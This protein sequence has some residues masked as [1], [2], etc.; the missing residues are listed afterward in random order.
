[1]VSPLNEDKVRG[2]HIGIKNTMVYWKKRNECKKVD[3][4]QKIDNYNASFGKFKDDGTKLYIHYYDGCKKR[5]RYYELRGGGHRWPDKTASNGF[6]IK[7]GMNIG[8]ASHE[9]SAADEIVDF[10]HLIKR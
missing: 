10:F 3:I 8:Y 6:I 9:I 4:S 1:M 2:R 7:K 5:L